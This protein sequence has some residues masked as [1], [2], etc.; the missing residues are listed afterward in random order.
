M[1]TIVCTGTSVQENFHKLFKCWLVE[2]NLYLQELKIPNRNENPERAEEERRKGFAS[3]NYNY[4]VLRKFLQHGGARLRT[5][6]SGSV[7]TP[8]DFPSLLQ[9]WVAVGGSSH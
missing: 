3:F 8:Y 4:D 7:E 1:A 9:I 6:S 5:H 2:Q